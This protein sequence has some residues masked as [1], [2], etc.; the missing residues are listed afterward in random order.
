MSLFTQSTGATPATTTTPKT[1]YSKH[2]MKLKSKLKTTDPMTT[3]LVITGVTLLVAGI[4]L[5]IVLPLVLKQKSSSTS[6]ASSLSS[7]SSHH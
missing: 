1:P 2:I 5:A 6:S 3:G 4:V 7:L